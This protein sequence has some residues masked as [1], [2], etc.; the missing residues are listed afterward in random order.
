MAISFGPRESIGLYDTFYQVFDREFGIKLKDY[1][2]ESDQ[3]SALKAVGPR[4]PRHL[5]CLRHVLKSLHTK[6]CCRFASLVGNLIS[7][8]SEKELRVL[9]RIYTRDFA[10]GCAEGGN[11]ETKLR[12]CLKKVGLLFVN[13][14]M[15]SMDQ[16]HKRW[17]QVSM[18]A[19]A[20]TKMPSTLNTIEPLN[21]RFNGKTPRFNAFWGSLHG[22]REAIMQKI[23]KFTDGMRYNHKYEGLR[24]QRRFI[25]MPWT[26]MDRD[27][28]FFL[29]T[30]G[31]CLCCETVMANE[32]YRVDC[33]CG[34]HFGAYYRN[35]PGVDR[36]GCA[37][38]LRGP[39]GLQLS[40]VVLRVIQDSVRTPT[41]SC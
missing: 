28:T 12:R 40:H 22:L 5:F 6:D 27:I 8:R 2:L 26:R 32:M 7:A 34:H 29:I 31:T 20:G 14:E 38:N 21:G 30:D 3:G 37:H 24:V 4:H 9:R 16:E 23:E 19:R 36:P 18:L 17:N 33:P 15:I 41:R 35:H 11:E 1:I 25:S 39:F 10:T 13:S